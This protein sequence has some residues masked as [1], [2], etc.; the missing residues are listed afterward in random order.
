ML[1]RFHPFLFRL[2]SLYE[3]LTVPGNGPCR[4]A[5]ELHPQELRLPQ[6]G[7]VTPPIKLC[8]VELC[9]IDILFLCD[10]QTW[11]EAFHVLGGEVMSNQRA[12]QRRYS[13][14]EH[15]RRFRPSVTVVRKIGRA[16]V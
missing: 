9:F 11:G 13:V 6:T 12:F 5:D 16:H 3:T 8:P 14:S 2:R 7:K 15:R 4:K 10:V 1:Q